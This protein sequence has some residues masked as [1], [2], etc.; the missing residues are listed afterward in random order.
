MALKT[1]SFTKEAKK[2]QPP[3][4]RFFVFFFLNLNFQNYCS[5]SYYLKNNTAHA[6][7]RRYRQDWALDFVSIQ[8]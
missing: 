2:S 3:S 4:K 1:K 7:L 5:D 8:N 6:M